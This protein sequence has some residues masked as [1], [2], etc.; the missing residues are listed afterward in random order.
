LEVGDTIFAFAM[1]ET[2]P[3]K[4]QPEKHQI[5]SDEEDVGPLPPTIKHKK[6]RVL[7]HRFVDL[8]QRPLSAES[9][10]KRYVRNK[11]DAS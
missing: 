8:T 9:T 7:Q 5:D 4:D 3:A 2:G 6:Q 1:T 10:Q 11:S